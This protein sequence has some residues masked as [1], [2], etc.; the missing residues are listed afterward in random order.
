M[1]SKKHKILGEYST[2][3]TRL[4]LYF[5]FLQVPT[6]VCN[7]LAPF[8]NKDLHWWRPYDERGRRT[9]VENSLKEANKKTL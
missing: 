7:F 6:S 5:I 9:R 1:F 8:S 2:Q 4:I 3:E